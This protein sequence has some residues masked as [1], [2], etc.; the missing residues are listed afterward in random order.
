[1][2]TYLI[3]TPLA[4]FKVQADTPVIAWCEVITNDDIPIYAWTDDEFW[5][6]I[7][8]TDKL[9]PTNQ[10]DVIELTKIEFINKI[11]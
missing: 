2:K 1:M 5:S 3:Y 10:K 9:L 7:E 4:W 11:K 8:P 6:K